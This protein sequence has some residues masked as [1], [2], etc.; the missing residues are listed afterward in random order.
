MNTSESLLIVGAG[1]GLSASLGRLFKSEG[2]KIA[3]AARNIK[4]LEPLASDIDALCI[5]C[6]AA[7]P[8][9]VRKM[10]EQIDNKIG[11]P[12]IV[13]YN[14]SARI[15]GSIE[16]LDPTDIK[17]ALDT[18]CYGAFLVA[19]QAAI[20]MLELGS[21]SIFF[22]GA[23]A[24]LKGFANSS[25]FAMG[26]FGLRGLAQSLAR[27]LHPKNIH[28]GH[29]VIDGGIKSAQRPDSGNQSLLCPD[30]IA[31]AYLNFHKQERSSWAWEIEL[32]P[33]IESF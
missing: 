12:S 18:T 19:Q 33:W 14:P 6:D 5:E 3:L 11:S 15:R 30:E 4:K 13:I 29:F 26:K 28:I 16:T 27:E 24:G 7:N 22:T 1:P 2:M 25:V 23:S 17:T 21:G 20:R 9:H 32:R 8:D 10:F 31:K